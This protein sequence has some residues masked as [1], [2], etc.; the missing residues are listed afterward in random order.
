MFWR[1]ALFFSAYIFNKCKW[2]YSLYSGSFIFPPLSPVVFQLYLHCW[3][4]VWWIVSSQLLGCLHHILPTHLPMLSSL[5]QE[6]LWCTLVHATSCELSCELLCNTYPGLELFVCMCSIGL[7]RL[8]WL[9]SRREVLI[10]IPTNNVLGLFYL[11]ISLYLVI[12]AFF[13]FF[14]SFCHF[15]GRSCGVPRLGVQSEP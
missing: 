8:R 9:F 14:L 5:H 10:F 2:H 1:C 6:P 7:N 11:C 3:V 13:F 12:W 4:N 15:L